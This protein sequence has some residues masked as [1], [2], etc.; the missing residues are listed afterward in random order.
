MLGE[1]IFCVLET[2]LSKVNDLLKNGIEE[3]VHT[4]ANDAAVAV[5]S[6]VS[7]GRSL[8][9]VGQVKFFGV[10]FSESAVAFVGIDLLRDNGDLITGGPFEPNTVLAKSTGAI[11]LR[12]CHVSSRNEIGTTNL[13]GLEVS[14]FHLAVAHFK[15]FG[16]LLVIV[17][18]L[19]L[20]LGAEL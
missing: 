19:S 5:T 9:T 10:P 4:L 2:L 1:H 14:S 17:P 6:L 13:E 12:L 11:N 18:S 7:I 15:Y 16:L 3:A 8:L 20:K